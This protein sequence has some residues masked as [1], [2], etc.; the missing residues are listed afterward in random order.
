LSDDPGLLSGVRVLSFGTFVAGNTAA[1]LLADLGAEVVKIEARSRSD[2]LR[3]PAY[4]IGEAVTEPSGIPNTV[5]EASLTRGLRN[6]SLDLAEDGARALFHRLVAV[7]DIVIENFGSPVLARWRCGYPD[8][9]EHKPNLVMLSLSGYGRD[10]PRANYLAY[11]VTVASYLGLASAWGYAHGTLSD[12]I[13]GATGALATVAALGRARKEG[14]PAYLDMAQVDTVPPLLAQLYASPLNG[15]VDSLPEFNRSLGSWLCG[16]FPSRGDDQWL[17]VEIEDGTDWETLCRALERPDL[18]T[19]NRDEATALEPQ[20]AQ[21]LGEWVALCGAYTAMHH[22]QRAGLAAGVVQDM[23]DLWRDAQLRARDLLDPVWQQDLGRVT[24]TGS[25]QRWSK[26]P[27]RVPLPP[28]R[29]GEHTRDILRR[30][31]SVPD[32]ELESLEASG[33]IFSAG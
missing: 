30:W 27:G 11:G 15:G 16:V 13:A 28:A 2:V 10:G 3:M 12:Y 18:R 31:L 26:S 6:M 1:T 8:L 19:A 24:Y 5:M 20:L 33:A 32:D 22:L 25:P 4:A 21:A 7:S 17:A 29:L 14:V 23:E 9:L